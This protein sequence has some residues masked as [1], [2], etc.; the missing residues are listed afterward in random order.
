MD[1]EV[2]PQSL[3][4]RGVR[5]PADLRRWSAD[6]AEG[7]RLDIA[8]GIIGNN[9][10][11]PFNTS[12]YPAERLLRNLR[13]ICVNLRETQLRGKPIFIS[14]LSKKLLKTTVYFP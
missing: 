10:V 12:K 11:L 14:F 8:K 4:S 3:F 7:V 1:C 2:V 6:F 9:G 5:F 13:T